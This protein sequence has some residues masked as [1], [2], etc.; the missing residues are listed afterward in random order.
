MGLVSPLSIIPFPFEAWARGCSDRMVRQ[1][2]MRTYRYRF[3]PKGAQL[4]FDLEILVSGAGC[5]ET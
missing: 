5:E 4:R 2:G 3:V 1:L